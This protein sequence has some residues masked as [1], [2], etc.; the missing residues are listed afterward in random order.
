MHKTY[1]M[2]IDEARAFLTAKENDEWQKFFFLDD[3]INTKN[4][5]HHNKLLE[6]LANTPKR[7]FGREVSVLS[8]RY[9]MDD[10]K[11]MG[12]KND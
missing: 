4:E 11:S 7:K 3:T 5:I 8:L 2:P 10:L 12:V 1:T 9:T 6:I